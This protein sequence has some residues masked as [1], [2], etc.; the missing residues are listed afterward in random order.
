MDTTVVMWGVLFGGIGLGYCIYGKRQRKVIPLLSGIVLMVYPLFIANTYLLVA[1][2][3]A[4]ICLP[5]LVRL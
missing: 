3:M 4:L 2:G 1:I 5:W